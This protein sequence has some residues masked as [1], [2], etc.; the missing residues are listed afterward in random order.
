[1]KIVKTNIFFHVTVVHNLSLAIRKKHLYIFRLKFASFK[2]LGTWAL[3]CRI[4]EYSRAALPCTLPPSKVQFTTPGKTKVSNFVAKPHLA[5]QETNI[6]PFSLLS[7]QALC[8]GDKI[9]KFECNSRLYTVQG[10]YKLRI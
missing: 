2:R 9:S 8:I 3:P 10:N 7:L 6:S 5:F 1:M 4:I